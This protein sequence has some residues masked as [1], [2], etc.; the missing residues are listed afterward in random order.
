MDLEACASRGIGTVPMD[1][2]A[3]VIKQKM[4]RDCSCLGRWVVTGVLKCGLLAVTD[5]F[6]LRRGESWKARG[7]KTFHFR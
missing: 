6:V 4:E 5:P 2:K 3:F 7:R 1:M